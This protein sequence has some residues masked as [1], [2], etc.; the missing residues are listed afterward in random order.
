MILNQMEQGVIW[1]AYNFSQAS[2]SSA[3]NGGNTTLLG[4]PLA[5]TTATGT[6]ISSY[7][8]PSD[9]EGG[10]NLVNM[11]VTDNSQY[12]RQNARTSNYL[13]SSSSYSDLDCVASS[14]QP[15]RKVQGPFYTDVSISV[16]RPSRRGQ[17]H[18]VR[19]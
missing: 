15:N 9:A 14:A 5:N 4:T 12:A 18:H 19:R 17:Q 2:A 6:V 7:V 11:P 13:V 3:W 1:N 16:T 8:C 10:S